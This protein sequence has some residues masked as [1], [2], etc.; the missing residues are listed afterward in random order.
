MEMLVVIRAWNPEGL[1]RFY[2]ALGL[3]FDR[4]RHGKGPEHH[5][6]RIGRSV[7]EIYPRTSDADNTSATRLGFGVPDVEAACERAVALDGR[8]IRA[9]AVSPWGRRAVLSDPEG[10]TVELVEA[11][12]ARA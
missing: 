10:H 1:A 8:L 2:S 12:G 7:F 9:A 11:A 4:E 5:A 6:C 3:K